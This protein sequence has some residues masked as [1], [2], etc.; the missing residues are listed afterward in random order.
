MP[1]TA[2]IAPH[3]LE[4]DEDGVKIQFTVIDTPGFG[5][6]VNNEDA[7][8]DILGYIER[9]YDEVLIE[10]TRIKRNP[11]FQGEFRACLGG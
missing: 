6:N 1:V 4:I 7:F 3:V 2:R 8:R 9:Q 11:K 5:D 10:E